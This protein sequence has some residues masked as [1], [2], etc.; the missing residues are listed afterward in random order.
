MA[1]R[2]ILFITIPLLLMAAFALVK[3]VPKLVS[4]LNVKAV[5]DFALASGGTVEVVEAGELILS[6]RGRLGSTDF[7]TASFVLKDVEGVAAPSS[8]ILMRSSRTG[9]DGRTTL[10][11]RRF[12]VPAPGRYQLEVAGI[13]AAKV[14]ADSRLV[15]ARP[16]GAPLIGLVLWVVMAAVTLLAGL[17]F[18]GIAVFAERGPMVHTPAVGSPVHVGVIN[19]VQAHMGVSMSNG[20][21]FKVFHLKTDGEWSYFDGNEI[22]YMGDNEWQET[23]WTVRALLQF[24]GKVLR[25]RALWN[26]PD[27]DRFSLQEFDRQVAEF[28]ANAHLPDALFPETSSQAVDPAAA[29]QAKTARAAPRRPEPTP[30]MKLR[31]ALF[32]ATEAGNLDA[33]REAVAQGADPKAP[34]DFQRTPLHEAVR[35]VNVELVEWLLGQGA[36]PNAVD[37]DGRTPLHRANL[38]HLATLLSHGSDLHRLDL[39]GNTALHIAA[40]RDYSAA[41]CKAL[42]E[43]GIAVNARNHAGLT[44]LHFAVDAGNMLNLATLIDL[45]ADVNARTTADYADPGFYAHWSIQGKPI[46]PAGSTPISLAQLRHKENKWVSSRHKEVA[47]FLLGKGAVERK[48]WQFGEP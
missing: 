36:D 14:S 21:D 31:T 34:G 27:N 20:H 9:M 7:A 35:S 29:A 26:L 6:L 1:D 4:A 10:A 41:M 15:L 5:A 3:G 42:V 30:E 46:T 39:Q 13:D 22:V 19:A 25:V 48:W 45:G 2:H 23:D 8:T 44:P 43:A 38:N 40:E 37:G 18:S 32:A 17:I 47:E 24:E 16:G 33:V 11:V 28:R 12:A